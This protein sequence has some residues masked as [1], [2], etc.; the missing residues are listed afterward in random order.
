MVEGYV[1]SDFIGDL[2]KSKSISGYMFMLNICLIS[3]KAS[4]QH[5]VILSS[6]EA[7]FIAATEAAKEAMWLKGLLNELWLY[8]KTV[9]DF[10]DN[11]S[12]IH[13]IK[14]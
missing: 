2:D 10:C 5:V 4:L 11:Q 7:E 13:L 14:N 8:Q 9:Q 12:V 6:I 3:W 1:D